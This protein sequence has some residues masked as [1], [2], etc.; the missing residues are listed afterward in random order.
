MF[1]IWWGFTYKVIGFRTE[2]YS[3]SFSC[4]MYFH[5]SKGF[6]M[7]HLK[8]RCGCPD[9]RSESWSLWERLS[10]WGT[11]GPLN[12]QAPWQLWTSQICSRIL[13]SSVRCVNL[14]DYRLQHE[15]FMLP[16]AFMA[17]LFTWPKPYNSMLV[18]KLNPTSLTC[19]S[20]PTYLDVFV[21]ICFTPKSE[22]AIQLSMCPPVSLENIFPHYKL[23]SYPSIMGF[24]AGPNKG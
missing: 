9:P 6:R 1:P 17:D 4:Y 18:T 20:M 10:S 12:C 24:S 23:G 14:Y 2:K 7:L 21:L 22:D 5:K 3:S 13:R 15:L 16:C 19:W 11:T 8:L